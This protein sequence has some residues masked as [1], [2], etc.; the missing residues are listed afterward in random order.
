MLVACPNGGFVQQIFS[1]HNMQHAQVIEKNIEYLP[2]IYLT[3]SMKELYQKGK[4]LS[5]ADHPSILISGEHGTGKELLA[6]SIHYNLSPNAQFLTVNCVNLS[7]KHVEEKIDR[8]FAM[9]AETDGTSAEACARKRPTLFLRDIGKLEN[10]VQKSLAALLRERIADASKTATPGT[11][12]V[13]LIFSSSLQPDKAQEG[14]DR[15]ILKTFNPLLLNILPL[16]DRT[17]DIHPLA[18]FFID[19]YSKEYGKEIGGIHSAA[20]QI[21]ENY[22]WT[23][24]VSELRDVIENA[25]ILAQTPLITKEDIRFNISKKSIALE[26]FLTREDFFTLEELERIYI[27]TVFRRLKNNKSKAAKVLGI[28]RNTLQKKI[29]QFAAEHAKV[30][31]KTK[32]KNGNQRL[33]F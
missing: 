21:L 11:K 27:Q 9:L 6:K 3:E 29:D 14:I 18:L 30:Q 15:T 2:V 33:L 13:R 25:V 10:T 24:N 17:E 26:S 1:A 7:F 4:K 28:S 16:R 22:P 20:L 12:K 32:K 23:G 5:D 8:C 31:K 19:K